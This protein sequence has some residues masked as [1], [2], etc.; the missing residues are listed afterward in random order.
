MSWRTLAPR[1][2]TAAFWLVIGAFILLIGASYGVPLWYQIHD[3][4]VIVITA[5]STGSNFHAGDAVVMNQVVDPSQLRVGQV[6]TFTY[7]DPNTGAASL[8]THRIIGFVSLPET[9][10]DGKPKVDPATGEGR[11]IRYIRT[12]GDGSQPDA[13]L[14]EITKIR[15]V[16]LAVKP[17]WGSLLSWSQ[18]S[19]GRLALFVPPLALLLLAEVFSWR[20]RRPTTAWQ[21]FR[22]RR[23]TDD[24]ATA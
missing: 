18:S 8:L 15:G 17:H 22:R 6:V 20:G 21:G 24:Q 5:D 19:A 14:T 3:E 13:Q 2:R 11:I 23:R 12:Q 10:A 1:G 9:T 4:R 7:H 16:A